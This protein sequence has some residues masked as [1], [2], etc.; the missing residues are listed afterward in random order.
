MIGLISA[1]LIHDC[2]YRPY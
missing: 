2:L 1:Q